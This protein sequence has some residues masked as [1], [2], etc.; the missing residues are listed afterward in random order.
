M[1]FLSVCLT[2]FDKENLNGAGGDSIYGNPLNMFT[3]EIPKISPKNLIIYKK[4]SNA[5]NI[6]FVNF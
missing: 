1:W 5:Y 4:G 3:L 2:V 6:R